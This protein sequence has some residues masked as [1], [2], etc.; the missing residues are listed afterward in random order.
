MKLFCDYELGLVHGNTLWLLRYL[1]A[2]LL[3]LL[4]GR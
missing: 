2:S 3:V 4:V 1:D